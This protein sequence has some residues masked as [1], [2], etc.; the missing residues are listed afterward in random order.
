M[1]HKKRLIIIIVIAVCAVAIGVAAALIFSSLGTSSSFRGGSCA[2]RTERTPDVEQPTPGSDQPQIIVVASDAPAATAQPGMD[3][4][5]EPVTPEPTEEP[6]DPYEELIEKADTSM[7]KDIVNI[8]L[9]GVDYAT[10]RETWSGKKDWHSDVMIVLAINFDENRAD[11]I[12]L[13]RDTYADIPGVKGIYKLNAALNCG[14]DLYKKDGTFNPKGPEK[15]CEA[16]EWMLGGIDVDYYYLV[17]MTS[18]K[19][20][21]DLCGGLEYDMVISFK[22]V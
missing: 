20:L 7:M 1:N 12:S 5:P 6:V 11:L 18:L 14:G 2:A 21:V 9:I 15:V 13:P 10:E 17:T 19:D 8:L 22:T 4:T 3:E 16:A